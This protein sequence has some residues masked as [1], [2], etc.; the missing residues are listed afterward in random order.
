MGILTSGLAHEL[1]NPANGIVNAIGPL[2]AAA[3][4]ASCV[5]PRPAVGQ[6]LE[7]MTELRR[8]DRLPV[9]P[10]ARF[11]KA[12]RRAGA[13][14]DADPRAGPARRG[15]RPAALRASR[16]RADAGRR[17]QGDVRTAAAGAGADQPASRTRPHAAGAGG[18]VEI[19]RTRVGWAESPS[20]S[21]TVARA[22]RSQLRERVFEPF[23]T[24][25]PPGVGHRAGAVAR[26]RHRAPP[27]RR[28]RDPRARA[29][30]RCSWS[31]FPNYSV[32]ATR[33]RNAV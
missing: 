11:R 12:V 31:S 4:A 21:P 32:D 3:A 30:A 22:C 26:A 27:R 7:V 28:A 14:A 16:S 18:W 9:A 5:D 25:K 1:R 24:T 8:A 10:A 13:P 23:F 6:L 2:D 29:R 17:I 33:P 15:A 20:R 19:R